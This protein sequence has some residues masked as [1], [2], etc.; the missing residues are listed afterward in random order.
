[1]DR[2]KILDKIKKITKLDKFYTM[3]EN[4]DYDLIYQCYGSDV[5]LFCSSS[6][7]K[8]EDLK[9]LLDQKQYGEIYNKYGAFSKW[10][11]KDLRKLKRNDINEMLNEGR[12]EDIYRKYGEEDY[13]NNLLKIYQNDVYNETASKSKMVLYKEKY[14]LKSNI[15][16][17]SQFLVSIPVCLALVYSSS[18]VL[19]Q[20]QVKENEKTYVEQL[21]TYNSKVEEYA[22]KIKELNLN[23][24][25]TIMKVMDDTWNDIEGYGD[26]NK[27]IQGLWR[28]DLLEQNGLGVCRNIADDFTAKMNAIN[29]DYNARNLSVYID[30]DYYKTDSLSNIERT[31]VESDN[32]QVDDEQN[33]TDEQNKQLNLTNLF[34]N[35]MVTV[36]DIPD[37]NISLVIDPT[38]PSIGIIEDGKIKMLSTQ[39]GKGLNYKPLG[40]QLLSSTLANVDV[41]IKNLSSFESIDYNAIL[42]KYGIEAQNSAL[43]YIRTLNNRKSR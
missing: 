7:Y 29:P 10:Y 17:F 32:E 37:D 42:D 22:E 2:E 27:D 3:L 12:Y 35:H 4:K 39:E 16:N 5:F 8:K 1:M 21:A 26:P 36:L 13:N 31:I 24:L 25:E 11:I 19:F 33:Q 40:Q 20:Q 18:I 6:S 30:F 41:N 38:N 14:R 34:G 23:D 9:K 15:K 43:D 28:L